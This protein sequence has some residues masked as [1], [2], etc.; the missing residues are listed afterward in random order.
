MPIAKRPKISIG[1][2]PYERSYLGVAA[3]V[4][5]V[6]DQ[7]GGDGGAQDEREEEGGDQ[8]GPAA[9]GRANRACYSHR[10]S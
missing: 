3:P 2:P 5:G 10:S 9:E 7:A 6:D 8:E 1:L 4:V